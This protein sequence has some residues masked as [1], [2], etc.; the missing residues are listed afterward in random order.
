M[1]DMREPRLGPGANGG[2]IVPLYIRREFVLNGSA[3]ATAGN[4]GT[5]FMIADAAY[6]LVSVKERHAT[7]GNDGGAVTG[8]L[9]KV[10]S[11]TAASAGTAMLSAGI[12]LKGTADTNA[13]GSLSATAANTRLA[14]GDGVAF[15]LTGTP[16]ALAGLCLETVWK[17]I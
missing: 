5:V 9:T 8:M 4:F 12:N 3:P 10:P 13:A 1:G 16:T 17:R 2:L 14:N 15:V 6:E 7:A 11:G